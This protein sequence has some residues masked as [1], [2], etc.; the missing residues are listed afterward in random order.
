[1]KSGQKTTGPW[2]GSMSG[3]LD[4]AW[5]R[6]LDSDVRP[7]RKRKVLKWTVEWISGYT[8]RWALW[9]GHAAT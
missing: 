5:K 7:G 6:A 1:M 8:R 3:S 4:V 2:H 9:T